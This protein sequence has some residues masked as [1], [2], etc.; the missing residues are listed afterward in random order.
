MTDTVDRA[1][2]TTVDTLAAAWLKAFSEALAAG[3]REALEA[4]FVE[5]AGWRDLVAFTWNLR[6]AHDRHAIADLLLAT[7]PEIAPRDFRIDPAW[8]T[9]SATKPEDGSPEVVEAFFTFAVASGTADGLVYLVA[10]PDNSTRLQARTLLTRLID[11]DE[12]PSQWP[13]VGRFDVDNPETRWAEHRSVR[14]DYS[15][16]DPEVLI[17]GG[18]QFGVMT[19][20]H[21][22]RVGVDA[23]IIDKQPRVGDAWRSRYESLFLHQPHNI[24][25]FSLMPFPVS[26]PEY[27]PKDKVADWFEAYVSSFDL[28]VWGGTELLSGQYDEAAGVWTVDVRRKDGSVRT[29]R[30]KHVLMATGGSDLPNVPDFPGLSDFQGETIHS[31]QFQDGKDYAGKKVLIVGTGTSAHDFALDIVKAGGRATMVQ[32]SPLIVIDLPTAN[33]LYGDYNDRTVPTDLV[34]FRFLAG[35][36]FHQERQAFKE[37]Q[38]FADDQDKE[39]HRALAE[40][41]LDVWSGEDETGFYYSYLSRSKGGY[42]INVGASNAIVAGDIDVLAL[43]DL[44]GFDASGIVRTDGTAEAYDVVILATAYLSTSAGIAKY[45]GDDLARKLGPVWGFGTDGEMRNVLK[46]TAQDGFW[47]MEGSIPMAR[48]HAPLMAMLVKAEL[49]GV[50][51]ASFKVD[52]H[53]SRTPAEPV[54]ALAPYWSGR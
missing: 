26:F 10:D 8:P 28:N 47:I 29:M 3:S 50:V 43:A 27:L 44:A 5:D 1:Q 15:D 25:H 17:V 39:L 19:A 4:L 2:P 52:G 7:S 6:Q 30:P 18:G 46:P 14:R 12:A 34:D 24:L 53:P 51:P 22:G 21:L 11:L 20:A 9:P 49:L 23:L 54:A 48:W 41:G 32:R 45:F 31:S 35:G 33:V 38:Q 36:V 13:A 37:F 16:R 42:Y 40:A